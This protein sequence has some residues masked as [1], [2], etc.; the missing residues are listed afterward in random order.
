MNKHIIYLAAGNSRRFGS[1]KLLHIFHGKPL[2]RY[3]LDM[4]WQFC[5]KRQ[6]CSLLVITQYPEI[7]Q[8]AR[9]TGI[10]AAESPD[11]QK[12]MSYTVK[13]ALQVL[14]DIAEDDF[15][16][17]VVADQPYLTE[18][19]LERLADQAAPG[20]ETVSAAYN[21]VPGNPTM[22]SARLVP[23]LLELQ[24]DEGGRKVIR[25]HS[26]IYVEAEDEKELYDIDEKGQS[27]SI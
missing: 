19:T 2:Y 22:F 27:D 9:Q 24:G 25:R 18:K 21:S 13:R 12:G 3:G 7:L 20:I 1:N 23:E 26:C 10:S 14:G 15:V 6:D 8:Y 16:I 17:F 5:K 4:V 11:S